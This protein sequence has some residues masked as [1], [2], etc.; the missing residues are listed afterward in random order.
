MTINTS[1]KLTIVAH[2][3]SR[4]TQAMATAIRQGAESDSI[5]GVSIQLKSPFNCVSEDVLSSDAVVLFTTE[6]FG[7]MSGALKDFFERIYY[8]CLDD[9]KRN[10]ATPYSLVI[11]AGLDGTGTEVAVKKITKGLKWKRVQATTLCKGQFQQYFIEQ[12]RDLGQ[13]MAASLEASII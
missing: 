9:P 8:P 7:Y 2:T 5:D 3:P 4:N 13:T 10:D 6:N 11:R 12:C 1:K